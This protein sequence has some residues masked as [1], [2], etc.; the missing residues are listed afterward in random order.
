VTD[1]GRLSFVARNLDWSALTTEFLPEYLLGEGVEPAVAQ[2]LGVEMT[3]RA[4]SFAASGARARDVLR[5]P[6]IEEVTGYE[7]AEADVPLLA[8]VTLVV[9]NSGLEHQHAGGQLGSGAVR[10][11]TT[12]AAG[13]LLG[14]LN[15][16]YSYDLAAPPAGVFAGLDDRYPRA[17]AALGAVLECAGRGEARA[18]YRVPA[19][20]P[21]PALPDEDEL[22][23]VDRRDDGQVVFDGIDPR[24]DQVAMHLL[25]EVVGGDRDLVYVSHLSRLSRNTEKLLRMLEIILAADV[26]VLT[27][28][29]L[30]RPN[31]VW[32]RQCD[33]FIAPVSTDPLAG[34]REL[35]GLAGSH[36]K[37][38]A[39]LEEQLT[40]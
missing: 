34:L 4:D 21:T 3:Q 10:D 29:M 8:A 23:D 27:T 31:D 16:R 33:A 38:V 20:L 12:L 36:R 25:K 7:P 6:W 30:L 9:R 17:W 39:S 40:N 11:I 15:P 32:V 1:D 2:A 22:L 5:A 37:L 14:Y 18:G 35:R 26:P 28:N 24:F 19:G 13:P